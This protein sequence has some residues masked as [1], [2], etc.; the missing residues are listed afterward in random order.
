[1]SCKRSSGLDFSDKA[2]EPEHPDLAII[3]DA[4]HD[5]LQHNKAEPIR[6]QDPIRVNLRQSP[7]NLDSSHRTLFSKWNHWMV[8]DGGERIFFITWIFIQVV[9]ATFGF[10]NYQ[11]KDNLVNA[12][13]M[14]GLSYRESRLLSLH[15][16]L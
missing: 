16:T 4:G 11:L 6:L 12:R 5:H 3:Q 9:L 1:M 7:P 8:N 2:P 10:V 14:F 15:P 13:I